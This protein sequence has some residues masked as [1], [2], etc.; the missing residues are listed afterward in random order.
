M[1]TALRGAA[2]GI[3]TVASATGPVLGRVTATPVAQTLPTRIERTL[4]VGSGPAVEFLAGLVGATLVC[5]F[6]LGLAA[7]TGPWAKV[8][9]YA[10]FTD[11]HGPNRH[12]PW[13][14]LIIVSHVV[15]L[16]SKELIV[17]EQVDRPAWDVGPLLVPVSALL[18]FAVIPLGD[19]LQLADPES[20]LAYVFA[21]A[22]LATL[23]VA[24]AG[25]ASDNK[26]SM[27]GGLRAIATNIAYEIPLV[28]TGASVVLFAGSLRLSTIVDAQAETLVTLGGVAIPSWYAFV[29]PFA[30]ALF[31]VASLAEVGRNPFDTPEAPTEI[32]A[33][34]QTE[35]SSVYFVL[36]YLGEFLHIFLS[37]AIITTIFLGGPAGPVLPGIVWFTAK[38]W[39]FFAFTQWARYSIPRFR[40][41][42]IIQVGW[43]GMLVCAFGNLVLTAVIVGVLAT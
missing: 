16:V 7:V 38:M 36:L 30:F 25:Y 24:M 23:G 12:G 33:G 28:V 9:L 5:S 31:V 34:I 19:G 17:P 18:G 13:G 35:Y 40:I 39:A 3:A 37:G 43:K 11:R 8:K 15:R 27:L 2:G 4:G 29:N 1:Q 26:F 32:V 21:V 6:L 14:L 41:D 42:Q 20:G 10:D 22:S